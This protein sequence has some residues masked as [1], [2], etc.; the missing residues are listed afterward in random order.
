MKTEKNILIAFILNSL[1]SIFELTG[2]ILTGSVAILSDALHDFGDSVSIGLSYFFERKSK[3]QPDNI[4]TY[5]YGRYSLLGSVITTLILIFGSVIVIFN[6]VDRIIH[7]TEI[8]YNGMILFAVFGIIVNF[9][10]ALYT[11]GGKS[12]NQKAVN[13][14]MLEDVLGWIVVLAGAVAMKFTDFAL[15]DPIMSVGV[16]IF[17]LL[18][19]A[20]NL[21]EAFDLFLDKVPEGID[22]EELKEHISRIN[23]ITDIHHLHVWSMNGQNNFATLHIVTNADFHE[24]KKQIRKELSN[25]GISHVTI[26]TERED[27]L[28]NHYHCH[29]EHKESTTHHCHHH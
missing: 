18:N 11:H 8:N 27:E 4:Y 21:K 10:A 17:I 6:A 23:G 20:K 14:H 15:I 3:K 19:A 1:F 16:A 7:P 26:E 28:C 2:G 25:H 24:T 29:I 9:T 13:L 22:I 5:G 12:L